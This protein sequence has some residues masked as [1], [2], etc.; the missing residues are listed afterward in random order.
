M[1]LTSILFLASG[2]DIMETAFPMAAFV[3]VPQQTCA[4]LVV[5]L[6]NKTL[7]AFPMAALAD[8]AQQARCRSCGQSGD[9]PEPKR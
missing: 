6:G 8:A 4:A 5:S 3:A 7:S 9:Q 2:F 1:A